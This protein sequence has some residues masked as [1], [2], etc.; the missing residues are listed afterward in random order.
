MRARDRGIT[1]RHARG[2]RHR[3]GP[4]TCTPTFQAQV[5]DAAV[6]KRITKTFPR[7]GSPLA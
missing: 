2:C 5:Y 6:G 4:C 1:A 3:D 7:G